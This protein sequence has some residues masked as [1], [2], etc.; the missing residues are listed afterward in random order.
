MLRRLRLY[1]MKSGADL[2][3]AS[4]VVFLPRTEQSVVNCFRMAVSSAYNAALCIDTCSEHKYQLVI[5]YAAQQDVGR[6]KLAIADGGM[7][8]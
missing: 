5:S 6:V 3:I 4:R 1:R 8:G 2:L 7:D